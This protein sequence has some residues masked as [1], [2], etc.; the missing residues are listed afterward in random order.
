MTPTEPTFYL[1]FF[2]LVFLT[3]IVALVGG[4]NG[5]AL[6]K[7][8]QRN[9]W[10]TDSS[11]RLLRLGMWLPIFLLW[12]Y[13]QLLLSYQALPPILEVFPFSLASV[14]RRNLFLFFAGMLAMTTVFFVFCYLYLT[15]RLLRGSH[16]NLHFRLLFQLFRP[17]F[18]R[19]FFF[20]A[21]FVFLL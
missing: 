2:S 4:N 1:K 6:G 16:L 5:I 13:S 12:S 9:R 14:N 3:A 11:V 8:I 10:L 21:F 17:Y 19:E 7:L 15:G 20:L 18:W